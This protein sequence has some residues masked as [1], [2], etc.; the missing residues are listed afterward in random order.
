LAGAAAGEKGETFFL[1]ELGVWGGD[2]EDLGRMFY[3]WW[4]HG[5][6]SEASA[7]GGR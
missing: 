4:S 5:G 7:K 1:E 6:A 2:E 3:M